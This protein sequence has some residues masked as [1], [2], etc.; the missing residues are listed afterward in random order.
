[1][2]SMATQQTKE[3]IQR[4]PLTARRGGKVGYPMEQGTV[5]S[6]L[7]G[8]DVLFRSRVF[9]V[10]GRLQRRKRRFAQV[11]VGS[12]LTERRR[13]SAG[14][15]VYVNSHVPDCS[16]RRIRRGHWVLIRFRVWQGEDQSGKS[17]KSG[18]RYVLSTK[19]TPRPRGTPDT[20][21]LP[22]C[23]SRILTQA[24]I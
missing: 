8:S 3:E 15:T 6:L 9:L 22:T 17:G 19:S 10:L 21:S 18:G 23:V 5:I 24:R 13:C 12:K 2:P 16:D 7:T 4:E 1:M 14:R 20:L 11:D